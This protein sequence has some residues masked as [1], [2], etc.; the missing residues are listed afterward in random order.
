MQAIKSGFQWLAAAPPQ[1][2]PVQHFH[3]GDPTCGKGPMPAGAMGGP[4]YHVGSATCHGGSSADPAACNVPHWHYPSDPTFRSAQQQPGCQSCGGG[5][6][7]A[8]MPSGG[9]GY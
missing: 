8:P 3:L 1:T 6:A 2:C 4:H 9:Y 5:T 7:P